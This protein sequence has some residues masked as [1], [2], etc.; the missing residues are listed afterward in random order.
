MERRFGKTPVWFISDNVGEFKSVVMKDLLGNMDIE[1]IPIIEKNTE[2]NGI[3][4]RFNKT[5]MNDVRT[6]LSTAKTEWTYRAW[7]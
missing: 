4:E 7:E 1:E 2:K 5:I 3:A 6:G